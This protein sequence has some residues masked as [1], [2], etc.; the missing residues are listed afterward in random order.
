MAAFVFTGEPHFPH[1]FQQLDHAVVPFIGFQPRVSFRA[2]PHNAKYIVQ[3]TKPLRLY[4]I[5]DA[6][7]SRNH[8]RTRPITTSSINRCS[9]RWTSQ[10]DFRARFLLLNIALQTAEVTNR[11][12]TERDDHVIWLHP[13]LFRR[14]FR[15]DTH[16]FTTLPVGFSLDADVRATARCIPPVVAPRQSTPELSVSVD[17][18]M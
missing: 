15:K 8:S 9:P 11:L 3:A 14:R 17:W 2:R 16:D 13:R 4:W 1:A 5:A 12:P 6:H 7:C 18:N 10:C